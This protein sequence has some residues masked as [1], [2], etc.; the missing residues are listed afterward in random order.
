MTMMMMMRMIMT[1]YDGGDGD[2]DEDDDDDDGGDAT[3]LRLASSKMISQAVAIGN[4]AGRRLIPVKI[5]QTRLPG[6][7]GKTEARHAT[8]EDEHDDDN[9]GY[10]DDAG[11]CHDARN[12][13]MIEMISS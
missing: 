3:K 8:E 6:R 13:M 4:D 12:A 10:D 5:M 11:D 1:N 7:D 9:A 2:R